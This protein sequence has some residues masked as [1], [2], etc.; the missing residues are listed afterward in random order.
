MPEVIIAFLTGSDYES[1]IRLAVAL[2]G[3]ADTQGAIA[4]GIAAAYYGNISINILSECESRLPSDIKLIIS[5]FD[6]ALIKVRE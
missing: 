5:E 1:T 3:D 6:N 2:G 4:G